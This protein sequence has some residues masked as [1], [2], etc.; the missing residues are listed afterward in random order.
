MDN[1]THYRTCH[2]CEAMCGVAIEVKG[3]RI[4]SIRGD[5]KDPLSHGH[6]CPKAVALQDLQEDPERLR[7]PVRK[8]STGWQEMEWDEAFSRVAE[9]LHST[10]TTHG[11]NSIGVYLG[12]PNVHNHGSLIATMPFLRAIGTQNRF[13][14]TSNDQLPHMLASLEM[15]GHQVLFPIP[16]IDNTDLFI[17]IGGNPMASNG[18]LMSVPDFRGRL[19]ALKQRGGKMIVVDPRRT[20]TA[21]QAEEFYFV[22]PGTDA[23]L[24][25]AMVN[26][27]FTDGLIHPGPAEHLIKD[28]DLLRLASLPFT[29]ETAAERTGIPAETIRNL[30]HQ[31]ASTPKAALYTRMGTST[32]TFGSTATWLAY[33]LN[34]L[35]GKLDSIGGVMFTQ[36]AIDLI[37]LGAMSGQRGHFGKRHSR[38]KG[39]PE[40][41][42]E[43][44]ASTMADEI[45]TPGEGQVRAFVT[46]AGNPVLSSPNGR[47]LDEALSGLDFMVSVDYYIN[48]TTRHADIILPPTAALERSHY[49]II[50]NMLAVRN[51][52]K[53]SEALFD[54]GPDSRHDWQILLELAHK[55]EKL[56]K[57]GKLPVRSEL[58][59]RAFKQL[60]PDPIVDLLLRTGPYG[61]DTG[62][63]RGILEPAMSLLQG[64]LPKKHALRSLSQL[65]SLNPQWQELPKGLSLK[66]LKEHPSG[67][68]L[69][70]LR[71]ALPNR[72]FTRDGKIN[73][74]PRRYLEDVE[75]LHQ[76]LSAPQPSGEL[77]LVGRRHVRSN[78]SWMH[79]SQRLVKGK[80][81]CTLLVHPQDASRLGLH[82]GGQAEISTAGQQIVLPVEITEDMMQG[83]VSIPH[84]WGH[85]REGTKQSTASRH[86]G[87]SI[88]D[89]LS[90]DHTDPVAG[91]SVLNGQPVTVKVWQ[92]KQQR[93][94]A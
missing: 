42:G 82:E 3:G 75:R 17:C 1:G 37:A 4:A 90:D 15:F 80:E 33:C 46:V 20:E 51:L 57:G 18:S 64:L 79:N 22:R 71:P 72:L 68:D 36:P 26:T 13:S 76:Q 29:P 14:A 93:K 12:N 10:R 84:G 61:T 47:R 77:L 54:A 83:V 9:K 53:Y 52:A 16:D 41:A 23:F 32:Q 55:L 67:I 6:I 91:T 30:A 35:T 86:P 59:W 5:D 58:G 19:K 60:G 88:N 94:S 40:F 74:A 73:L 87:A 34:I 2:L 27:L 48:E 78:N 70:A 45:L 7:K 49:D 8:T 11:R 31:L 38:V 66:R 28:I 92:P 39:L 43:Y 63:V 81:R 85:N 89:V 44:P 21:R 69:G 25:M 50:F 56:R 24:L 62:R 65:S